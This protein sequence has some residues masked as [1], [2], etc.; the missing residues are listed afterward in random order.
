[1]TIQILV[2]CIVTSCT[3]KVLE[4]LQVKVV[5]YQQFGGIL[6][7]GSKGPPIGWHTTTPLHDVTTQ[8]TMFSIDRDLLMIR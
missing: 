3:D 4:H 7:G 5:G 2:M 1:M 6:A 8:K